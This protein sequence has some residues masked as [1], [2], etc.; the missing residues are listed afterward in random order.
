MVHRENFNCS[1]YSLGNFSS[2]ESLGFMINGKVPLLCVLIY[3]PP[4]SNSG[5]IQEFSDLLALIMPSFDRVL[6]LGDFNIHVCCPSGSSF[7]MDFIHIVHSFNLAQSVEGPIHLKGH[8]LDIVLTSGLILD[9]VNLCENSF[10]VSDH[11]AIIFKSL[12]PLPAPSEATYV[13]SRVL[14]TNSADR[15]HNAFTTASINNNN[16]ISNMSTD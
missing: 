4:K 2:F 3:R 9:S 14:N 8:T 15:F 1:P 6:I 11:K 16:P 12:L 5:F 7:I 10:C 13:T